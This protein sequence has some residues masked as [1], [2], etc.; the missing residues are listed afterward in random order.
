MKLLTIAFLLY[1]QVSPASWG[2]HNEW[3]PKDSEG[4]NADLKKNPDQ[5]AAFCV[6]A[7]SPETA[8]TDLIE[9]AQK[10]MH[11]W[12]EVKIEPTPK[13]DDVK[14]KKPDTGKTMKKDFDIQTEP[15]EEMNE[16]SKKLGQAL[17]SKYGIEA[18]KVDA[19]VQSNLGKET[20][21]NQPDLH[22]SQPILP[23]GQVEKTEIHVQVNVPKQFEQAVGHKVNEIIEAAKN[24]G[25]LNQA[26]IEP[27]EEELLTGE[28]HE[29]EGQLTK[30]PGVHPSDLEKEIAQWKQDNLTEDQINQNIEA[31]YAEHPKFQRNRRLLAG[32]KDLNY[33][34]Y[35]TYSKN[36]AEDKLDGL[37]TE[38]GLELIYKNDAGVINKS[39]G[40]KVTK[41]NQKDAFLFILWPYDTVH[42]T[43]L[44]KLTAPD[45][46]EFKFVQI[47]AAISL[48]LAAFF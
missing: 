45:A 31:W 43:T 44:K 25:S 18:K 26:L 15:E 10:M 41:E 17:L 38:K 2:F 29:D 39:L 32:G 3:N 40:K 5:Q 21:K 14:P 13:P 7:T 30:V 36:R 20:L 8:S 24:D 22:S 47:L 48:F 12:A 19:A 34:L 27:H 35:C 16:A 42:T 37:I 28:H 46:I 1:A 23:P 9:Q 4:L 33:G 6:L 11:K